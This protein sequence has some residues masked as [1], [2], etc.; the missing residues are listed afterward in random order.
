MSGTA[1]LH[2]VSSEDFPPAATSPSLSAYPPNRP[3]FVYVCVVARW[4]PIFVGCAA[5]ALPEAAC[6]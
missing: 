4:P 3:C 1:N 6:V 5:R 2:S